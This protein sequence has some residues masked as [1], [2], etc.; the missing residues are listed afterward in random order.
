MSSSRSDKPPRSN[1]MVVAVLRYSMSAREYELLH[2]FLLSRAHA[3]RRRCPL[4][5]EVGAMCQDDY[6]AA[7]VRASTRLGVATTAALKGWECVNTTL[8]SRRQPAG[9]RPGPP[10]RAWPSPSARLGTSLALILLVHRLLRRFFMRLRASLLSAEAKSFRRRN[11]R[12]ARSLTSAMAPAIGSSLAGFCLAVCPADQL[13][14]SMALY[15]LT[16]ALEFGYNRL[17]ELGYAAH[18]P[19][20]F[21]AWLM[22]PVACGQLLHAFVF[23]RD[24]FPEA[25]GK[26]ILDHS[27]EYIRQRPPHYPPTL[28]WPAA[29][30]IVD[31]LAAISRLR[32]PPFV[33]PILFPTHET[34]A[35]TLVPLSSLCS[36]AHPAISSLSCALLHPQDPSC[37]RTYVQYWIQAFPRVARLVAL[38]FAAMS[39]PRYRAFLTSPI[40]SFNRLAKNI[41]RIS[42]FI[43]GAVGTC[44]GSICLFQTFLPRT[45]L[46][47]QRWF[48]GG[49]LGGLWALLQRK[50]GRPSFLYSARMSIDSTWKVGVKRGWWKGIK[51]GDVLLFVLSMATI[52]VLYEISPESVNSGIARKSLGVLRGE[53]WLDRAAGSKDDANA[54]H[55]EE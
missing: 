43:C 55:Y 37:L 44:W 4:P 54:D 29:T 11:P 48:L 5:A 47:T 16:R 51:N 7:A 46:P 12:V 1:A 6:M 10:P 35:K 17:E 23:D 53:G 21:G 36:S 2:R 13:R 30:H 24:C 34:L 42:L 27:P 18:T 40:S 32:W 8:L 33:S 9:R 49:V 25:Y 52:N 3:V 26:L 50:N 20:W 14:I 41:L 39:L 22:M 31:G 15:V 19:A 38:Y 45:F 28:H